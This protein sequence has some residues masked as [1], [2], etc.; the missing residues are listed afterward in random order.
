MDNAVTINYSKCPSLINSQVVRIKPSHCRYPVVALPWE[1]FTFHDLRVSRQQRS[2]VGAHLQLYE[3]DIQTPTS[4]YFIVNRPKKILFFLLHG[5]ARFFNSE[6]R[7]LS[8]ADGPC[9]YLTYN[10]VAE[11]QMEVEPSYFSFVAITLDQDW[12]VFKNEYYPAFGPLVDMWKS[13]G[14]NFVVLQQC[15]ITKQVEEILSRLRLLIIDNLDDNVVFLKLISDC[16]SIYHSM[17]LGGIP[18][19]Q[20]D[21]VLKGKLLK[22]YLTK[23]YR[24]EKSCLATEIRKQLGFSEWTLRTI[25]HNALG[26]TIY[27]YIMKL[28]MNR[29]RE[30]LESSSLLIKD[31]ALQLGFSGTESFVRSFKNEN[32]ISPKSYR[33]R[34]KK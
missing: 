11:F 21:T 17:L 9:F 1:I 16:L 34:Y 29:A 23:H 22:D 3:L 8:E 19:K 10:P 6:R 26:C 25:A 5:R 30:Q 20:F 32:G 27:R 7:Q 13:R 24:D 33:E 15:P 18:F 14:N 28:R 12:P 31:I 2:L 4:L